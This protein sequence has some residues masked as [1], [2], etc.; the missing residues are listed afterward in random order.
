MTPSSSLSALRRPALLGLIACVAS[1]ATFPVIDPDLKPSTPSLTPISAV[2]LTRS[3]SDRLMLTINDEPF[4]FNGVQLRA[5]KLHDVWGLSDDQVQPL[6]QQAADDGFTVINSQI[7]WLSIQPDTALNASESTFIRGGSHASTNFADQTSSRIGYL[8]G[9]EVDKYL[10][11]LKFDLSGYAPEDITAAKVR[12]YTTTGAW[13]GKSFRANMYGITDNDWAAANITWTHA[14]NHDG[15][16]IDGT[17][18]EDYFLLSTSPTWDQIDDTGYYDFDVTDFLLNHLSDEV[19]S[20]ILQASTNRTTTAVGATIDGA[21][22]ARPPQLIIS[23][24]N[25]FDWTYLDKLVKW[26]E[27]AGLKFEPV[28][29]G[30]ESTGAAMDS[31]VPYYVFR[32]MKMEKV[33]DDGSHTPVFKRNTD[34]AYGTYWFVMDKNDLTTRKQEKAAV[35]AMMNHIAEYNAANGDKRT[36]IGVDVANEPAVQRFHGSKVTAWQ[37]PETWGALEAFDSVQDFVDRTMWEFCINLA[38]AV[39]ESEYP[40]WTRANN[41]WGTDA[42]G[43]I[44]NEIMRDNGGTS[45]DFIGL[46]PYHASVADI[47]AYGHRNLSGQYYATGSN[48]LMVMEN[49]GAVQTADVLHLASL[50]GGSFYNLYELYGPDDFGLYVPADEDSGDYTPVARAGYVQGVRDGN[51]LL[52][53]IAYDLATKLPVAAGG[54]DLSFFNVLGDE[55]DISGSIR[56]IDISYETGDSGV[57]IATI[58]SAQEVALLSTQA[59]NF[60]LA[61]IPDDRVQSVETGYY[62]G[63]EWVREG[64]VKSFDWDGD[65]LEISLGALDCVRVLVSDEITE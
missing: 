53:K 46:D 54:T 45:L 30:S 50:A 25:A 20:F 7:S 42:Q 1:A 44:Y 59:A 43:V 33:N 12:I 60:T 10:T 40:V 9:S 11:Y 65:D 27:D 38:N 52:N 61:G 32:N 21:L 15:V 39:K 17:E 34:P 49:S 28:W 31:R 14:P 62:R 18:N 19:A 5:D 37:N 48:L 23:N 16:D 56:S 24:E 51:H 29:F 26:T 3:S 64:S 41:Y 36:V 22:G 55:S 4:F 58:H 57:G 8:T 2:D 6:F 35:L 63:T 13:N 47:F